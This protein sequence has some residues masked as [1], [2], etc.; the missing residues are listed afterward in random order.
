MLTRLAFHGYKP[1]TKQRDL[2]LINPR[3]VRARRFAVTGVVT[4]LKFQL[5][6]QKQQH[7]TDLAGWLPNS[8]TLVNIVLAPG[9]KQTSD[10]K[11]AS[12]V[13]ETYFVR[14]HRGRAVIQMKPLSWNLSTFHATH[15]A[16]QRTYCRLHMRIGLP[17]TDMHPY[18]K[19]VVH[20]RGHRRDQRVIL[21]TTKPPVL[22]R[23]RQA[24]RAAYRACAQQNLRTILSQNLDLQ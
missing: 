11:C 10:K 16:T 20:S 6:A 15:P 12:G 4:T 1:Q 21:R 7:G 22:R 9:R 17:S 2:I 13:A 19:Y 24:L 18:S 3:R 23:S 5:W 8:S 14:F